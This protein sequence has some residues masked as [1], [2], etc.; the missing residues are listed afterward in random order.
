MTGGLS[1]EYWQPWGSLSF[2]P[3]MLWYSQSRRRRGSR[4]ITR[5]LSLDRGRRLW[6]SGDCWVPVKELLGTGV[7]GWGTRDAVQV[8]EHSPSMH[9]RHRLPY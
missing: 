3:C 8:I 1:S 9:A 6:S 4:C 7:R 5:F 2:I